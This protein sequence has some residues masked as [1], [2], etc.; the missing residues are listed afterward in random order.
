MEGGKTSVTS[1]ECQILLSAIENSHKNLEQLIGANMSSV[2]AEI[3]A[4]ATV[5]NSHLETIDGR[6]NKLNGS[7]A[8]HE[9]V[10]NE[11]G[12][13]VDSF[14]KIKR[15]IL[16]IVGGGVVLI[17]AVIVLYDLV[18]LRGIIEMVR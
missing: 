7:V 5:T 1:N 12:N 15:N 17:L 9:K 2:R 18:G 8:R 10:I 11:R 16:Y 4:N 14:R 13:D 6:L 3:N